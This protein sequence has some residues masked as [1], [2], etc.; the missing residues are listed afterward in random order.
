MNCY[1]NFNKAAVVVIITTTAAFGFLQGKAQS[2]KKV[3]M[4]IE[5]SSALHPAGTKLKLYREWPKRSLIDSGIIN[6]EQRY[7][8]HV[9][10]TLP[11]VY[12]LEARKPYFSQTIVLEN[13][14][15]TIKLGADSQLTVKGGVLQQR[16]EQYAKQMKPLEKEWAETGQQYMK[17][18]N[19]EEKLAAEKQNKVVAEKVQSARIAAIRS[20]LNSPL[21]EWLAYQ[22][23]NLWQQKE[24][25]TLKGYF[26][27]SR[28]TNFISE[29]IEK[30]L[31]GMERNLMVGKKAPAFTLVSINGNSVSL[32]QLVA[33]NKYVL[34]DFWASWCT[35]CRSTNRNIAP[36][37]ADLKS[38]GIE[39]VSISV[40]ENKELW[41]KAVESD[42][43]PWPQLLSASMNSKAVLDFMVKTLPSTFLIN[44]EG[45]IVKQHV[46][47]EELKKLR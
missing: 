37:Y 3:A 36:L 40:D 4:D 38:R 16:L 5:F 35:P 41:K 8:L 44:K 34:L 6:N 15:C 31:Q 23:L 20:N 12:K 1:F 9:T 45:V 22:N 10:D 18:A 42:K 7:V 30:K 19:L 27:A 14:V 32:D 26:L 21:G 46:E 43:I 24:L 11:A 47:I 2:G 25:Q 29:E 39:V 13:G 28:K 17:A 33:D